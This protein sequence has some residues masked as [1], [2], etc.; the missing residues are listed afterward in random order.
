[1]AEGAGAAV[2]GAAGAGFAAAGFDAGAGVF[3]G[4]SLEFWLVVSP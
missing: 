4:W 3:E 2:V 1:V